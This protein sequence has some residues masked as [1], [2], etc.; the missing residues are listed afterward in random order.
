M[1]ERFYLDYTFSKKFTQKFNFNST[2]C[3]PGATYNKSV[4]K[5]E[6][7]YQDLRKNTRNQVSGLYKLDKFMNVK[8]FIKKTVGNC[9]NNYSLL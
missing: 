1:P 9:R 5:K 8:S 2:F 6:K 7:L 3:T 4:Q